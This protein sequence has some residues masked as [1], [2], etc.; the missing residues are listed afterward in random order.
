MAN[1]KSGQKNDRATK[2]KISNRLLAATT[3]QL[4]VGPISTLPG[5]LT[6]AKR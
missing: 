4:T 3:G 5:R 6:L 2:I 1:W